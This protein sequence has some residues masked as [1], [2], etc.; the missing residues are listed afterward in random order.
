MV[1][2]LGLRLCPGGDDIM[3]EFCGQGSIAE[4]KQSVVLEALI[5]ARMS[6]CRA[7]CYSYQ[8]ERGMSVVPVSSAAMFSGWPQIE[9]RQ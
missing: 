5:D 8:A 4:G 6:G 7:M 1:G 9:A 3:A 2:A